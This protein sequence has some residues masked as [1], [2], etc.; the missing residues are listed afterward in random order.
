[1]E[2]TRNKS[3]VSC[4]RIMHTP[5][6]SNARMLCV[7]PN[8]GGEFEMWA[9]HFYR[10]S[11][12][13]KCKNLKRNNP[14]LYMIWTNM[15]TRCE[16]KNNPSYKKY[17]GRGIGLCDEWM[18]FEP[19]LKWAVANGYRD[20]L[21]IDRIDNNGNYEPANCRWATATEQCRNRRNTVLFNWGGERKTLKEICD[22][23]GLNYKTEHTRLVR[24]G[25]E[26][27][28]RYMD[29]LMELNGGGS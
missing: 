19:F 25:H 20:D 11:N 24:H 18:T 17:G 28:Q 22:I 29:K 1:M 8:C 21:S 4:V 13:C 16:N 7:C 12:S 2:M 15:K 14:R 10:G 3:G 27:V 9:S 26:A 5:E 23:C 6:S